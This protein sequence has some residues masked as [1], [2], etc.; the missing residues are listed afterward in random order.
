MDSAN[1][2]ASRHDGTKAESRGSRR[3]VVFQ[4][5]KNP[6]PGG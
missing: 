6:P 3:S 5:I 4:K 1:A 2:S